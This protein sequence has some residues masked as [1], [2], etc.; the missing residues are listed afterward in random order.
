MKRKLYRFISSALMASMLL[1]DFGTMAVN[2]A[3][4]P[5]AV[6]TVAEEA[7]SSSENEG[8][9]E[10]A[11]SISYD[12]TASE[13]DIAE[14]VEEEALDKEG[15]WDWLNDVYINFQYS[16]IGYTRA[17]FDIYVYNVNEEKKDSVSFALFATKD[18]AADWLTENTTLEA[19][20]SGVISSNNVAGSDG[21]YEFILPDGNA[22]LDPDAYYFCRMMVYDNGVYHTLA[23]PQ[24]F[25]THEIPEVSV[26]ASAASYT[27]EIKATFSSQYDDWETKDW[28]RVLDPII[29]YTDESAKDLFSGK[30]LA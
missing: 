8:V 28:L 15:E 1:S 20:P 17:E 14:P 7:D 19:V 29:I 6:D 4:E 16:Y 22:Q 26:S 24:D 21:S 30:N 5:V 25:K 11:G 10:D 27:A 12:R 13:N 3:P 23:E 9:S 2:A 18:G